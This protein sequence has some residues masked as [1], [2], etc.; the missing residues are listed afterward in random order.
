MTHLDRL[1]ELAQLVG[2]WRS[3]RCLNVSSLLKC[4]GDNHL[5]SCPVQRALDDLIAAH[6]ALGAPG[7]GTG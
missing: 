7:M 6:N 2:A 3:A 1:T 5:A 4:D